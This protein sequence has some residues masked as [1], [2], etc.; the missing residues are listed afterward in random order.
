MEAR[1]ERANSAGRLL[2]IKLSTRA[3]I[4]WASVLSCDT[5]T[6]TVAITAFQPVDR[7]C[8]RGAGPRRQRLGFVF[9]P[10]GQRGSFSGR[11]QRHHPAPERVAGF[12]ETDELL[13]L[14]WL[15]DETVSVQ[16][17]DRSYELRIV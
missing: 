9:L 14:A 17:I 15:P 13:Q 3:V 8:P 6:T 2:P 12:D 11:G 4:I 10:N 16:G 5:P 7:L 1:R